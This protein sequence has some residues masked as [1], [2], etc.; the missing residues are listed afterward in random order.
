M[1]SSCDSCAAG[2]V[3]AVALERLRQEPEVER[4][5]AE[6]VGQTHLVAH[7]LDPRLHELELLGAAQAQRV[8][9]LGLALAHVAGRRLGVG[10]GVFVMGAQRV[11]VLRSEEHT[12]ELQ[13]QSNLVCRLLL[14][15]KIALRNE[16]SA[17]ALPGTSLLVSRA[18]ETSC[19]RLPCHSAPPVT[20][21]T[22]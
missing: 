21:R 1:H 13:S 14:D 6:H 16:R 8:E 2:V 18:P 19:P 10:I 11:P 5:V 9:A 12:S 3:L 4:P 22:S 15:K 7:A 20:Y 17:V